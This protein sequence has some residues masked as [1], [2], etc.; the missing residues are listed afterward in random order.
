[1]KAKSEPQIPEITEIYSAIPNEEILF[2]HWLG[3]V[4]TCAMSIFRMVLS[5]LGG[6]LGAIAWIQ[7]TTDEQ[8]TYEEGYV[9]VVT[10]S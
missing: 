6:W 8:F 3:S 10:K 2:P 9:G 4:L 1:M 5:E 7:C